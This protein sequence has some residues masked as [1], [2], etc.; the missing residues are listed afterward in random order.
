MIFGLIKIS[1]APEMPFSEHSV[2]S[3]LW[4]HDW[5]FT[6]NGS[7]SDICAECWEEYPHNAEHPRFAEY[8]FLDDEEEEQEEENEDYGSTGVCPFAFDREE[9]EEYFVW[10]E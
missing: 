10:T 6:R 8:P 9:E 5:F 7:D 4:C 1:V 2:D 3:L